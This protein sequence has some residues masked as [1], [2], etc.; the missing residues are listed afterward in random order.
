[1]TNDDRKLLEDCVY[2]YGSAVARGRFK[3]E[4]AAWDKLMDEMTKIQTKGE[5][6][7]E[8]AKDR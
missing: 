2:A 3:E 1:M 7:D 8:Y 5:K 6:K 4:N